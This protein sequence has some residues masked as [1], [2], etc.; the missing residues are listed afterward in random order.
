MTAAIKKHRLRI[1]RELEESAVWRVWLGRAWICPYCCEAVRPVDD[2]E[3]PSDILVLDAVMRHFAVCLKW[4][5]FQGRP[6]SAAELRQKVET[7]RLR[8]RFRTALIENPCWQFYDV[9]R[10]WYCPFC[11]QATDVRVREGGRI[12]SSVLRRIES[13]LGECVSYEGG[14]GEIKPLEYMKS[15]VGYANRTRKMADQ[16]RAKIEADASWRLRDAEGN[17][18][19]P[20][21]RKVIEHIDFSTSDQMLETAPLEIARHLVTACERFGYALRSAEGGPAIPALDQLPRVEPVAGDGG[22]SGSGYGAVWDSV[23]AASMASPELARLGRAS[24]TE[25]VK[26]SGAPPVEVSGELR[27]VTGTD[28][29]GAPPVGAGARRAIDDPQPPSLSHPDLDLGPSSR[30]SGRLPK[31]EIESGAWRDAIQDS[32]AQVRSTVEE[33]HGG[34]RTEGLVETAGLPEVEGI[35][36]RTFQLVARTQQAD[37]LE[38]LSLDGERVVVAVGTVSTDGSDGGLFLPMARNFLRM[39]AKQHIEPLEVLTRLNADLQVDD[40]GRSVVSLTYALVD[41]RTRS[42]RFARAGGQ[43]P[44]LFSEHRRSAAWLETRG[45][46]LGLGRGV[47]FD[48]ALEERRER[49]RPGDLLVF[50]THG[51][52][53]AEAYDHRKL[54][55]EQ[56]LRLVQH[57]GRH[58]ADYFV[59]K[60][61][62]FFEG[63]ARGT[64]LAD[65]VTVLALKLRDG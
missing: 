16:I 27:P 51:A 15:V 50:H 2:P 54:G 8:E 45:M 10:R 12:S 9:S 11:A 7:M 35:E 20:F 38:V 19:C 41:A 33:A 23:G 49:L 37:L 55:S 31:A 52:I 42:L 48:D 59:N 26:L 60:F 43:A 21:C 62:R 13:H 40:E 63:W 24:T 46:V 39:H 3:T 17:W 32:L 44:V 5:E 64:P 36:L 22:Q 1:Q 28:G 18:V 47:V 53:A 58:E 65:D 29:L 61:Q 30:P 57:Y 34:E 4:L 25:V 56:F 14:R 6:L